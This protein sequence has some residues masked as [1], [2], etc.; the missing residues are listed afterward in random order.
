MVVK[1]DQR[2]EAFDTKKL[3]EGVARAIE[4]RPISVETLDSIVNEVESELTKEY[5]MEIPSN[6][7]GEK[8]LEK[9]RDIDLVAYIRFAS[10]YRKFSDIDT[11]MQELKKL[12]AEYKK[13]EKSKQAPT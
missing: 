1:A 10:V 4:K 6:V 8:I 13:M 5:V 11:F 3:R 12:K 7:I 9:L 2:R